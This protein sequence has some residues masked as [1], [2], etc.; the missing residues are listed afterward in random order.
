MMSSPMGKKR[1]DHRE[2]IPGVT[3]AGRRDIFLSMNGPHDHPEFGGPIVW[4]P[5]D[6]HIRSSNLHRFMTRHGIK[7]FDELMKRSTDDFAWF[8]DDI[9]KHELKIQFTR[10]Y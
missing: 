5:T 1:H 8:W 6:S 2:T 3:A 10:P 9:L 7:S 4:R